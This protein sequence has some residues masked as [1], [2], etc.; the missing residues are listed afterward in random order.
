MREDPVINAPVASL[1][2]MLRSIA[3]QAGQ[4]PAVA[5]DGIFGKTT[6]DAVRDFQKANQLPVTGVADSETFRAIVLGYNESRENLEA[7][8]PGIVLFPSNLQIHPGQDHPNVALAQSMFNILR[9]EFSVFDRLPQSGL[10]DEK[11]AANLRLL[12]TLSSL[13]PTGCLDKLTWNRLNQL[14]RGTFD[15]ALAPSQG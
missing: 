1:Q 5:V 3:F 7:A 6:E 12:Q 9:R 8:Q 13:P 15:R 10:L 11:T 14:Y 2:T 4:I